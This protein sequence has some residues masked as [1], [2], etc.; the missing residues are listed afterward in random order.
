MRVF[1][2]YTHPMGTREAVKQGWSWPAF[3][4]GALWAATKKM[5]RLALLVFAG[6]MLVT[7]TFTLVADKDTAEIARAI[8]SIILSLLFGVQGNSWR[9][10]SL[11]ARGYEP[12]GLVVA[13]TPE[14]ALA[15][16]L[17]GPE[18][19]TASNREHVGHGIQLDGS[20]SPFVQPDLGR[21]LA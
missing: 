20:S 18:G 10:N 6:A 17:K 3:F 21:V 16:H 4:F 1:R 9:E 8:G 5:G 2:I 7:L 12:V 14:G 19:S 15:L 11:K 13:K